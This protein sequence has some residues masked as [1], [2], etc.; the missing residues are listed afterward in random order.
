[1]GSAPSQPSRP[2]QPLS[3][4]RIVD[5]AVQIA[6]ERGLDALTMRRLG[7]ELGVEA[8]SLYNH[9][10]DKSEV[11]DGIIDRVL[12]EITLPQPGPAWRAPLRASAVEAHACYRRH[13]WAAEI[14][15][16][17]S[18]VRVVP[19][20]LRYIESILACLRIAGFSPEDASHGYH[21]IDSH[22]LGFTLWEVGHTLPAGTATDFVE[23]LVSGIDASEF[24]YLI[25]HANEHLRGVVDRGIDEFEF[26][27]DLILDGLARLVHPAM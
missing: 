4:P 21:A 19:A 11:I 22:T 2:R 16:S 15:L 18:T 5:V 3:L 8:M 6:D 17:P 20:R 26:G 27:L 25:E 13:P 7:A 23:G 14:V 24:P 10:K 12:G 9:V 1:V